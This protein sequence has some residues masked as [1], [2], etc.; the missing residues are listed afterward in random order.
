MITYSIEDGKSGNVSIDLLALNQAIDKV[1]KVAVTKFFAIPLFAKD[2][3]YWFIN[4]GN[5]QKDVA[6]VESI[7][8]SLKNLIKAIKN[9]PFD[10]KFD[11]FLNTVPI[12]RAEF[13]ALNFAR[14]AI[15]MT[16]TKMYIVAT[17]MLETDAACSIS[18][19]G[20]TK[21]YNEL[22]KLYLDTTHLLLNMDTIVHSNMTSLDNASLQL[23][24][25]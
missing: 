17:V 22:K 16:A 20:R 2:D 13:I 25:L 8:T 15:Y 6:T 21:Q 24:K 1:D 5:L 3:N 9:T 14:H 19:S 10:A 23:P 11:E 4:S 12:N 7:K 18:L